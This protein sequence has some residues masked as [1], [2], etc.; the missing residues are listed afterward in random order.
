MEEFG[1][2]KR[3]SI[4]IDKNLLQELDELTVNKSRLIE[5]LVLEHLENNGISIKDKIIL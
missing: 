1:R 5:W 4:T 3:V 2:K